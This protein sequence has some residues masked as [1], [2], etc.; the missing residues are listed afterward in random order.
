MGLHRQLME[1]IGACGG[2]GFLILSGAMRQWLSLV[3]QWMEYGLG[4]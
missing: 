2:S 4:N 1:L 3:L